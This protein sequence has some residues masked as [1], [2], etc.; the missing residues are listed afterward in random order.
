LTAAA[1]QQIFWYN[2]RR[3]CQFWLHIIMQ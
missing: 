3:V 1:V 2:W